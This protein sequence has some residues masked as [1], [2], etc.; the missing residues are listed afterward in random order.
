MSI[1]KR[2][3]LLPAF[4]DGGST[5]CLIHPDIL[6]LIPNENIEKKSS[7]TS[8]MIGINGKISPIKSKVYITF[9]IDNDKYQHLFHEC[10]T[11][12]KVL[13]GYD[14]LQKNQANHNFLAQTLTL[15]EREIALQGPTTKTTLVKTCNDITLQPK[16]V[17]NIPVKLSGKIE[18]NN[19]LIEPLSDLYKRIP[20]LEIIETLVNNELTLCRAINTSHKPIYLL[21]NIAI[22]KAKY[23]PKDSCLTLQEFDDLDSYYQK[24][25]DEILTNENE[26]NN[27]ELETYNIY[28]TRD[29]QDI[30]HYKNDGIHIDEIRHRVNCRKFES[31]L[32][33]DI[34]EIPRETQKEIKTIIPYCPRLDTI[35][36]SK[37]IFNDP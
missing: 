5:I 28:Y 26:Q 2:Q 30:H 10:E 16:S 15:N 13:L 37:R 23:L 29:R 22:G 4:I 27:P 31:I 25:K 18:N 11:P 33:I 35:I 7:E 20:N 34:L 24:N 32:N 21:E 17:S 12:F 3:P 19:Y 6:K 1:S 9:T 8:Y 36:K 14:F